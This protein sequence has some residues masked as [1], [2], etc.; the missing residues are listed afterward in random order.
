MKKFPH[1]KTIFSLIP[2]HVT[3]VRS[4][5]KNKIQFIHH[6]REFLVRIQ[7]NFKLFMNP[8]FELYTPLELN[9]SLNISHK[10]L[11][12]VLNLLLLTL[13]YQIFSIQQYEKNKGRF[14]FCQELC[15]NWVKKWKRFKL[16]HFFYASKHVEFKEKS[17]K[18]ILITFFCSSCCYSL[19]IAERFC[20]SMIF[21]ENFYRSF[22]I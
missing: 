21:Y 1:S 14:S 18:I 10:T 6:T 16:P 7:M 20:Y 12:F 4:D 15:R 11:A 17:I 9:V 5:S 13:V 2:K 8:A 22:K 3:R 19:E